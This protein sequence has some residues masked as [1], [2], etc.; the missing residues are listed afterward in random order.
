VR[1]VL[2]AKGQKAQAEADDLL[3]ED[4]KVLASFASEGFEI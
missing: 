2:T 3:A 4:A 1:A